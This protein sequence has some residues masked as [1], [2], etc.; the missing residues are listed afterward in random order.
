MSNFFQPTGV[1]PSQLRWSVVPRESNIIHTNRLGIS[2]EIKFTPFLSLT[3]CLLNCWIGDLFYFCHQSRKKEKPEQNTFLGISNVSCNFGWWGKFWRFFPLLFR[4]LKLWYWNSHDNG[5]KT[6]HGMTV[7]LQ[8][9]G[10]LFPNSSVLP[11][12]LQSLWP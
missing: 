3:R 2:K 11:A 7:C 4:W 8:K 1:L 9:R 12:S 6:N 10:R 5:V